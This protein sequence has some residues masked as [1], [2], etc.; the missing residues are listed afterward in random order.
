MR[1]ASISDPKRLHPFLAFRLTK[2]RVESPTA[3]NTSAGYPR[4]LHGGA[5]VLTA[6]TYNDVVLG[7]IKRTFGPLKHAAKL[8]ARASGAT[9]RTA[10]NWLAGEHAPNGENLVE[11]MARAPSLP[12][13]STVSSKSAGRRVEKNDPGGRVHGLA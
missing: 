6:T 2:L 3:G 1:D 9:P 10:E 4:K 11:L 5:V 7:Y 12:R 8:L 13:R